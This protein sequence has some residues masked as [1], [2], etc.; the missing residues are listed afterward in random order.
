MY[1][2]YMYKD[3]FVL[4]NLQ[5]SNNHKTKIT[6]QPKTWGKITPYTLPHI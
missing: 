1:L 4:D 5:W 6:N 3:E 2:I